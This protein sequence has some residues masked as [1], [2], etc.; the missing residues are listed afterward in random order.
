MPP[1][2]RATVLAMDEGLLEEAARNGGSRVNR[3]NAPSL[4]T[5]VA[6]PHSIRAGTG[7]GGET[8][9]QG[10]QCEKTLGLRRQHDQRDAEGQQGMRQRVEA[11]DWSATPMGPL[12]RWPCALRACVNV[13]LDLSFPTFMAW[14]PA[15]SVI[16]NDA[17]RHLLCE[18]PDPLGASFGT[19]WPLERERLLPFVRM[20]LDGEASKLEDFV[21]NLCSVGHQKRAYLD[22]CLSPLYDEDGRVAGFFATG[23]ETTSRVEHRTH[24][25]KLFEGAAVGLS[26]LS[27]DGRFL[28]VNEAL[29]QML[30]RPR[31]ELL[32]K[33]FTDVTHPDDVPRSLRAAKDV[34][35]HGGPVSLDKRYLRPDGSVVPANSSLTVVD[36]EQGQPRAVLAVT[37]DLTERQRAAAALRRAAARN[38]FR[39]ALSDAL[40]SLGSAIEAQRAASRVLAQQLRVNRAMYVE[41]LGESDEVHIQY[42][43]CVGVPSLAG[44]HHLKDFGPRLFQ[45]LLEGRTVNVSDAHEDAMLSPRQKVGFTSLGIRSY[46][47]VPIIK[48]GRLVAFFNVQQSTPRVF[49]EDEVALIEETAERAW[50]A[51]Q[52]GQAEE[53]LQKSQRRLQLALDAAGLGI[54]EWDAGGHRIHWSQRVSDVLG[55]GPEELDAHAETLRRFIHPDDAAAFGALLAAWQQGKEQANEVRIVRPDQQIRWVDLHGCAEYD[56]QGQIS[57]L[58]GTMVEIT[59]RKQWEQK[60][61]DNDRRK[62]EF[63]AT[64][65]HELRNPLA[66][67]R[68]GLEIL[69]HP[70]GRDRADRIHAMMERQVNILSRLVDDL[71]EVS[72]ITRGVIELRKQRV[73]LSEVVRNAIETSSTLIE[74]SEHNL[75]VALPEQPLP[76][77][78][79]PMRLAQVFANLINN[80]A[81]YTPRKGQIYIAAKREANEAVVSVRDTGIGITKAALPRIFEM[82]ARDEQAARAGS[83]GLGIG[84][85]LVR[86]LVGMHGGSV[87]ARS[88]GAGRGAEFVVRLPLAPEAA[89]V[90]SRTEEAVAL[91]VAS[92]RVL[93]VDDNH[94]AA[95]AAGNLLEVTG[96]DVRVVYDGA[97]ALEQVADF[98]PDVILLDLGMPGMDGYEVARRLRQHPQGKHATLIALTGWGQEEDRKRTRETGFHHHLVKPLNLRDLQSRLAATG[99]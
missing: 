21:L 87:E 48:E 74:R 9:T 64:L 84:L 39:V 91:P 33:R 6:G 26:E 73:D 37:V 16:Y 56:G 8:M 34:V 41:R 24:M 29:C 3:H 23:I 32:S 53:A 55:V 4:G 70:G 93:V 22:L 27:L 90:A 20:A 76:V 5:I 94:D 35:E 69:R 62:D 50:H 65:A 40:R 2:P 79:D 51:V 95:D 38:D 47:A 42:D 75:I 31:N 1:R 72:R 44:T 96:A 88:E 86:S 58:V 67:L 82:F 46:V 78:G 61:R 52:R 97:S 83:G 57:G 36:D 18:S 89:Q 98:E 71:L 81:R 60:L 14:G 43:H 28:Y 12:S 45:D 80:S 92:Q 19:Q 68:N 13:V 7:S 54:W 77:N 17:C 15:L 30:R 66:P 59:D 99:P 63:L 11:F 85:T 49:D 25:G 10:G